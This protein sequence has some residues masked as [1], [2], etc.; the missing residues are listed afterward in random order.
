MYYS[1][2]N[3]LTFREERARVSHA[4]HKVTYVILSTCSPQSF[5][6]GG[7]MVTAVM[8]IESLTQQ[9][10]GVLLLK[11]FPPLICTC[12]WSAHSEQQRQFNREM[13]DL[14]YRDWEIGSIKS[15]DFARHATALTI[16]TR[17][18]SPA[19]NLSYF[20]CCPAHLSLA[21]ANWSWRVPGRRASRDSVFC[22]V[23]ASTTPGSLILPWQ[24]LPAN[25]RYVVVLAWQLSDK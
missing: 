7:R 25:T 14:N 10:A 16:L 23:R 4:K 17:H 15:T 13:R 9:L 19:A 18:Y 1:I 3:I 12:V 8:R 21:F 2:K 22:D 11:T 24:L 20:G 5:P 6:V